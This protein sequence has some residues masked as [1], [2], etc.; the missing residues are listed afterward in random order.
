M[1][2]LLGFLEFDFHL[3]LASILQ[4]TSDQNVIQTSGSSGSSSSNGSN[5]NNNINNNSNNQTVNGSIKMENASSYYCN[6]Y[7]SPLQSAPP[8]AVSD[9]TST[10]MI[11]SGGYS[12][13]LVFSI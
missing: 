9:R 13:L 5:N 12:K 8:L 4:D 7:S 11:V 6:S 2:K 3:V 10:S 1:H